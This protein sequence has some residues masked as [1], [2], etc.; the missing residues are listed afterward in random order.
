[1]SQSLENEILIRGLN[2]IIQLAEV[3]SVANSD[4]DVQPGPKMLSAV[5]KC[6]RSLLAHNFAVVGDLDFSG[7][8]VKVKAWPGSPR[9]I[10][11]RIVREWTELKRDPGLSEICWIE[12]TQDGRRFG[13]KLHS[14]F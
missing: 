7:G 2:D 8:S 9:S 12:L 1:M 4:F 10:V 14:H 3:I 11:G 5:T 6:V 13:E